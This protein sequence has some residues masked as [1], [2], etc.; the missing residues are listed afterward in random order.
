M[1]VLFLRCRFGRRP[2][3]FM[4]LKMDRPR[5]INSLSPASLAL[6]R[7]TAIAAYKELASVAS[8]YPER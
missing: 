8:S 1:L 4:I 6:L 3:A 7:R 2:V 5:E